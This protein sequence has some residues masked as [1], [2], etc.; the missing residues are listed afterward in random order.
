M[1]GDQLSITVGNFIPGFLTRVPHGVSFPPPIG[2][3]AFDSSGTSIRARYASAHIEDTSRSNEP[4]KVQTIG[5]DPCKRLTFQGAL[6]R[7]I[8]LAGLLLEL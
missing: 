8:Q 3:V 2:L 6:F 5:E 1:G 7:A 4:A